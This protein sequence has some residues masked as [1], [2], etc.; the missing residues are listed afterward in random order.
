MSERLPAQLEQMPEQ[1]DLLQDPSL[2]GP[3]ATTN[4]FDRLR[5]RWTVGIAIAATALVVS[6][7]P[8]FNDERLTLSHHRYAISR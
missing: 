4:I 5:N 7:G 3:D 1:S 8:S 6:E 2:G